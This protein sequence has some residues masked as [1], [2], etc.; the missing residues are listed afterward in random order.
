MLKRLR[1]KF[2]GTAMLA[3]FIVFA[4]LAAGINLS[5]RAITLRSVDATLEMLARGRGRFPGSL[6]F[7]RPPPEGFRGGLEAPMTPETP[8]ATRFFVVWAPGED[9][10][11]RMDLSSIAAVSELEAEAYYAEAA[12]KG[13]ESGFVSRYRYCRS[14]D[15]S[16]DFIVFLD[17][18]RQLSSMRGVFFS[19]LLVAAAALL[20]TFGLVIIL[21]KRSLAP[22]ARSIE[23]QKR[24]IT[25]ASHELKTPLTVIASHADILCMEDGGN[26]WAQGIRRETGRMASLVGDLVLL[27]RWDEAEP[28]REAYEF[29]LSGA[30]WDTLTP[31]RKLAEARG[32][33]LTADVAEGLRFTGD[34]GAIQTAL[35]TLLEN[36]VKYSLPEGE[37]GVTLRRHRRSLILE[38]TN[39]CREDA[40]LDLDRLF[41]R[42]YRA[43]ASRTRDSGGSGVG[44]SIAKAIVEGHG[45][46]IGASWLSPGLICFRIRLPEN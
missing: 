18:T 32:K 25:D 2:I 42:F 14:S 17:C 31:F 1:R 8:F 28:I 20:V 27:S 24:F 5:F 22:V 26:E 38:V 10:S 3:S 9:G 36:A 44:L 39:P 43:D 12:G 19:S 33:K 13:R 15:E 46:R 21:S 35:S 34:E 6:D 30:V 11:R 23:S 45:G 40:A 4:L 37:I 7:D 41:D 16:G 29:D